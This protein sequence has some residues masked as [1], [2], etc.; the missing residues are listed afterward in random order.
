MDTRS[1][2][3]VFVL[4]LAGC[5]SV[6]PAVPEGADRAVR[7]E[8]NGDVIEEYRVAGILRMVKVTPRRGVTYYLV[9]RNGDGRVDADDGMQGVHYRLFSW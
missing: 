1:I 5:A 2:T 6:P 3:F 8:A 9:D 4:F 7:T